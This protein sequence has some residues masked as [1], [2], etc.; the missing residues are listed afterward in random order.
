LQAVMQLLRDADY[1]RPLQYV[2]MRD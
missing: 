1:K 2:N